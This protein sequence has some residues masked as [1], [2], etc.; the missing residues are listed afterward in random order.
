MFTTSVHLLF[1]Y[2]IIWSVLNKEFY[3]KTVASELSADE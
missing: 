2:I 3:E 1:K